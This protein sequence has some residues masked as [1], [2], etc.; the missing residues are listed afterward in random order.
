MKMLLVWKDRPYLNS[1]SF[2]WFCHSYF[3]FTKRGSLVKKLSDSLTDCKLSISK[4]VEDKFVQKVKQFSQDEQHVIDQCFSM[5][6]TKLNNGDSPYIRQLLTDIVSRPYCFAG[7]RNRLKQITGGAGIALITDHSFEL[8]LNTQLINYIETFSRQLLSHINSTVF[9]DAPDDQSSHAIEP[10][11]KW[12]DTR[13]GL[14]GGN[15]LEDPC[16]KLTQQAAEFIEQAFVEIKGEN[17]LSLVSWVEYLAEQLKV[18]HD[19]PDAAGFLSELIKKDVGDFDSAL[20]N[21]LDEIA[22]SY[23]SPASTVYFD[24]KGN[25][26]IPNEGLLKSLLTLKLASVNHTI[27][28]DQPLNSN[29]R[30]Y[31]LRNGIREHF[32]KSFNGFFQKIGKILGFFLKAI[33]L[34]IK[35]YGWHTIFC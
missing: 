30:L 17:R 8:W 24:R 28:V 19:I 20:H 14:F 12:L 10:I 11:Y 15:Y 34:L 32:F 5:V 29:P 1:R 4:Q 9:Y 33:S 25:G 13:Y 3:L 7:M 2:Q 23:G 21:E 26:Y 18:G 6:V 27:D 31:C 35:R 16:L 22:E